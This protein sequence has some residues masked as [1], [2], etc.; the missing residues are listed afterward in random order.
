M[1]QVAEGYFLSK[2]ML[3]DTEDLSQLPLEFVPTSRASMA[4]L[5]RIISKMAANITSRTESVPG[6]HEPAMGEPTPELPPAADEAWRA[7]PLPFPGRGGQFP[8]GTPLGNIKDTKYLYGLWKNF[9][10]EKEYQGKPLTEAQIAA[11]ANFRAV[12]D[13]MGRHYDFK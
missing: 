13:S 1:E 5:K 10:V 9:V 8:R 11:N 7:V 6:V 4:E 2:G 3:T 12:L